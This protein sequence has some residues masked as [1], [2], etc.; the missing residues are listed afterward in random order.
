M[1]PKQDVTTW[2]RQ[3][4]PENPG[5]WALVLEPAL[6]ALVVR[7]TAGAISGA[8]ALLVFLGLQ[9][10][11]LG[12]GDLLKKERGGSAWLSI[13]LGMLLMGGGFWILAALF[14]EMMTMVAVLAA[15]YVVLDL[16]APPREIS[17]ELIGSLIAFPAALVAFLGP[18]FRCSFDPWLSSSR[19][20]AP[21]VKHRMPMP[22]DGGEQPWLCPSSSSPFGALGH[23]T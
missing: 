10:F 21:S 11:T 2:I 20:E 16:K 19:C 9:P 15:F 17:K 13:V 14:W 12:A 23:S 22:A 3:R 8:G 4:L 5:S 6:I 1:P 7:G 18:C